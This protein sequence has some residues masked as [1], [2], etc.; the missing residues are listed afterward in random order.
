MIRPSPF[1]E[2]WYLAM[3]ERTEGAPPPRRYGQRMQSEHS[4]W[5]RR[6]QT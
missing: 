3:T 5:V 1:V 2:G 4:A 6:V